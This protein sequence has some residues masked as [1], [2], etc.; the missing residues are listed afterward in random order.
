VRAWA[1]DKVTPFDFTRKH[2]LPATLYLEGVEDS[3][4]EGDFG[5]EYQYFGQGDL[6][7]CGAAAK[8]TVVKARMR[9]SN[10]APTD[11]KLLA[12][13][14]ISMSIAKTPDVR[15]TY[16]WSYDGDGTF[17]SPSQQTTRFK[18]GNAFTPTQGSQLVRCRLTFETRP[19]G[20]IVV[21]SPLDITAPRSVDASRQ[22]DLPAQ[23][24]NVIRTQD[25]RNA[26]R[27]R[28]IEFG[29]LNYDVDYTILDQFG[30]PIVQSERGGAHVT[31]RED[32]PLRSAIP[33]GITSL[34]AFFD[35]K[36]PRNTSINWRNQDDGV[37]K[38]NLRLGP[39]ASTILRQQAGQLR[40]IPNI[41]GANVATMDGHAW[42]VSVNGDPALARPVTNNSLRTTVIDFQQQANGESVQFSTTYTVRANP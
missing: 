26:N 33:A 29:L 38:D 32:V 19:P 9:F 7:L 21:T 41:V 31:A 5:F 42:S 6:A 14:R 10:L 40:F 37:I 11:T 25:V 15:S 28:Q 27:A 20:A 39:T 16:A 17:S 30:A 36:I 23:L 35:E 12:Q 3:T 24:S 22:G 13:G 18:A 8:G 2:A 4:Q 1:N 34:Q